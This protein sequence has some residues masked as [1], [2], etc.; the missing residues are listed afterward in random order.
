[1][2]HPILFALFFVASSA[3]AQLVSCSQEEFGTLSSGETV[4]RI[5]LELNDPNDFV[6]SVFAAGD[7]SLFIGSDIGGIKNSGFGAV[8]GDQLET[9]FCSFSPDICL[10]SYVTIGHAGSNGNGTTFYYDGTT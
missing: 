2:K 7:N 1:M 9:G 3:C 4:Y 6:Q 8:T 10:D 5:F